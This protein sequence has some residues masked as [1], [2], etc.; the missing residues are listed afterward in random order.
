MTEYAL[1]NDWQSSMNFE[2]CRFNGETRVE[3]VYSNPST[4]TELIITDANNGNEYAK[5][6]LPQTGGLERFETAAEKVCMPKGSCDLKL[7][8]GKMISLVSFR[9]L[10]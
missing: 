1:L 7:T 2:N 6:E 10:K 8:A 3:I 4:K 9:F 5:L